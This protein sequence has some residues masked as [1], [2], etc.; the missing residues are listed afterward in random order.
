MKRL[1]DLQSSGK[2]RRPDEVV[3]MIDMAAP[4]F[5]TKPT[6]DSRTP[7]IH[8]RHAKYQSPPWLEEFSAL[9]Q[10]GNRVREVLH[11]PPMDN[12]VELSAVGIPLENVCQYG[13]HA[14]AV[15]SEDSLDGSYAFG[16]VIHGDGLGARPLREGQQPVRGPATQLEDL[17]IVESRSVT[18]K[19]AQ[20]EPIATVFPVPG[21]DDAG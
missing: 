21:S 2:A 10:D 14:A 1:P 6:P 4:V 18:A 15:G 7:G 17:A 12:Q 9:R 3:R 16:R 20:E 13:F 8:V 5:R 11:Q 19:C